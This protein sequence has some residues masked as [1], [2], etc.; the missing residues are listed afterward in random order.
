MDATGGAETAGSPLSVAVAE[1]DRETLAMVR[2]ALRAR[3]VM[4]AYQPVVMGADPNLI[5]FHEGLVRVLD[6]A[7]RIIPARDFI[8]AVETTELGRLIDCASL[9][10]GLDTLAREPGLRL[11]V[12]M[13]ARSIGYARWT[14]T[15][16]RGL[17]AA[18]TVAERLILEI[19]EGSA[20]QVPEIVATFMADLQHKGISFALDDFGAGFTAFR[21]FKEFYF[22]IVKIDGEFIRGVAQDPDNQVLTQALIMIAQQFDMFTVAESVET[23]EDADWLRTQGVDCLQGY[24]YGAPTTQPVWRNGAVRRQA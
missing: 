3:R 10:L 9:E 13:S 11:A 17:A 18:P 20:M 4:L 22:D 24:L 23:V 8:G 2:D 5:A 19:T 6:E 21:Y 1:R 7:G 16:R 15:L 12:N 14:E